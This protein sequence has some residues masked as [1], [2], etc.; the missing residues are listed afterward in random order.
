MAS[1]SPRAVDSS[2]WR[3]DSM[4]RIVYWLL[5]AAPILALLIGRYVWLQDLPDWIYQ[6]TI[7]H[8][9]LFSGQALPQFGWKPY[10]VPNT[11]LTVELAL[12]QLVVSPVTAAKLAVAITIAG[13]GWVLPRATGIYD[14]DRRYLRALIA[15][16]MI[17]LSSAF[18]NGFIA[19]QTGALLLLVYLVL[20]VSRPASAL[21]T[22]YFG[23]LIFLSHGV[24][25]MAFLGLAAVRAVVARS[26]RLLVGVIP[27]LL[28]ATWY[29]LGVRFTGGRWEEFTLPPPLAHPSAV[30][31]V[32][33][34]AYS[35][36]KLGP[37]QNFILADGRSF[38][39]SQPAIYYAL[40]ACN[41]GFISLLV[42]LGLRMGRVAGSDPAR[43]SAWLYGCLIFAAYLPLPFSTFHVV[44]LGERLLFLGL[45]AWVV[46]APLPRAALVLLLGVSLIATAYDVRFLNYSRS[47]GI[48]EKF[49]ENPPD[50]GGDFMQRSLSHTRLRYFSHKLFWNGRFYQYIEARDFAAP[51]FMTGILTNRAAPSRPARL[52]APPGRSMVADTLHVP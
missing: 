36:F 38:L 4:A 20:D 43:R 7:A 32:A 30:Q 48:P 49:E 1:L 44:N 29:W 8:A 46:S 52:L 47:Q 27:S 22:V 25:F 40:V 9:K 24:T 42:L 34:K 15:F 5:V 12:M 35:A 11:L 18:W 17:A 41:I 10:P 14:P 26:P 3:S 2:K 23:V 16:P 45:V 33:W 39:E 13:F 31:L 51:C 21:R 28:L 6:G 50:T 19:Y 37:F